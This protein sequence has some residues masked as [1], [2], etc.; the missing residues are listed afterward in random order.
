MCLIHNYVGHGRVTI[1][2]VKYDEQLLF[3]LLVVCYKLLMPTTIVNQK[4][5]SA[6]H[7]NWLWWSFS[8]K[9]GNES[10]QY[11]IDCVKGT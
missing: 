4:T 5:S 11:K 1:L 10:Q 9:N 3:P 2:V 7:Y 6:R 8:K